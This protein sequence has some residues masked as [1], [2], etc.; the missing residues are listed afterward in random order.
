MTQI[1]KHEYIIMIIVIIMIIIREITRQLMDTQ[2]TVILLG[3]EKK[4]LIMY[5]TGG[6]LY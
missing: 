6:P 1:D 5:F 2:A 4:L 3:R